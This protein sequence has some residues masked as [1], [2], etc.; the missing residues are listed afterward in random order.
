MDYINLKSHI[1]SGKFNSAYYL[2][3]DD[4]YLKTH[5]VDMFLALVE[6]PIFNY[7]KLDGEKGSEVIDALSS[8][9]VMSNYKLVVVEHLPKEIDEL[10][11]FQA[12][13]QESSI[14]IVR[15]IVVKRAG[16]KKTALDAFVSGMTEINC[17]H[18]DKNM[19]VR[20]MSVEV[21]KLGVTMDLDAAHLLIDYLS[22]DL[23]S[24]ASELNKLAIY[25]KDTGVTKQVVQKYAHRKQDYEMWALTD[26]LAVGNYAKAM[27]V[28]EFY[29]K[30]RMEFVVILSMVYTHF[31]K[32]YYALQSS[33]EDAVSILGINPKIYFKIA[34]SAKKFGS[35]RLLQIL[36]IL[37]EY[38]YMTKSGKMDSAVSARSMIASIASG[39]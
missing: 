5:T 15:E 16:K 18:L 34:S 12:N 13:P 27:E 1:S 17:G 11:A 29:E 2:T 37:S 25:C 33:Q 4:E 8:Y 35:A 3:G 10:V 9:P 38:D 20:W 28:V 23:S 36:R 14:L 32:L 21:G 31:H 22:N 7:I 24:I 6:N 39:V 30:E 19:L 26:A